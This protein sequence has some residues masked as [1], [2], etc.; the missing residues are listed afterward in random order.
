MPICEKCGK[1]IGLLDHSYY[2]SNNRIY[3]CDECGKLGSN[4]LREEGTVDA[5]KNG[6]STGKSIMLTIGV[7]FLILSFIFLFIFVVCFVILLILG[8]ICIFVG[9]MIKSRNVN[10][11]ILETLKKSHESE[12][13][14]I[15]V[16]KLRYAKGEITKEQ[17]EQMKKDLEK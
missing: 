9:L 11:E 4:K 7:I 13:D 14:P 5:V 10:E 16:L 3:F 17:Y 8:I 2:D 1:R 12:K 15:K 6:G